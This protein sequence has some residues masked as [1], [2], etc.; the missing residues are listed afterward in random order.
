LA[1]VVH[2]IPVDDQED[3]ASGLA[4]RK[5]HNLQLRNTALNSIRGLIIPCLMSGAVE[6]RD[7]CIV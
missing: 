3:L 1:R 7:V 4:H 5:I 6:A 2:G